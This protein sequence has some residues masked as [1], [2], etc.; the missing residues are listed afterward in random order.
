MI[1]NTFFNT[2]PL[3]PLSI[4]IILFN[5]I[6]VL[7][8]TVNGIFYSE[9]YISE[10]YHSENENFFS[11]FPRSIN[12]FFYT[13]IV[14]LIIEL[15]IDFFFIEEKKIKGIFNREKDNYVNIKVEI[16]KLIIKIK[17]RYLCF[18]IMIFC[19]YI[20][21]WI[22]LECFNYVYPYT[23][24]DWIKS[25]IALIIIIQILSILRCLGNALLRF[26]SFF[27]R[28]EKIFKISNLLK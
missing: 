14:N 7:Y 1:V 28:S 4:K 24:Y 15:F 3:R 22:Y 19:L 26:L 21:F 20:I 2:E 25:S 17:K 9:G 8:F 6:L 12:R 11:F 10:I 13:A 18:F 16:G 5:F 23:Q 27:F